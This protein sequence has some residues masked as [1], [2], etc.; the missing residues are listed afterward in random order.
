MNE[1][2][3]EFLYV[4]EFCTNV[5]SYNLLQRLCVSVKWKYKMAKLIKNFDIVKIN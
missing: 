1:T 4:Y 3:S 2:H 5:K